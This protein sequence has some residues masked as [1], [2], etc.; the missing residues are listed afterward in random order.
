VEYETEEQQVEAIKKWWKENGKLVIAG[1]VLGFAIIVSW[2]YYNDSQQKHAEY[3][4]NIYE[5]IMQSV[6]LNQNADGILVKVNELLA[7]Y[8]DTPYA[9]LSALVLAKKQ[10]KSGDYTKAQQQFEWVIANSGQEEL[11]HI[12][13]LRLARLLFSGKKYD[14]ALKLL[15]V[16]FPKSFAVMY[17]ELKGDLFVAQGE[18]SQ[19]RVAYDKAIVTSGLQVGKWLKLKR[20]DLG[21][22]EKAEPSA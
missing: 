6:V 16:D 10:L 17:E 5:G 20:D 1:V 3:A 22:S 19:A 9:S 13:R 21:F 18:F 8:S 7:E 15:N 4:A 2:R 14:A 11:R 12:A